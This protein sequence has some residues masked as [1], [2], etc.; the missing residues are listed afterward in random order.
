LEFVRAVW[1]MRAT[2]GRDGLD[3]TCRPGK[4]ASSNDWHIKTFKAV[5]TIR[6][7]TSTMCPAAEMS[8]ADAE[9]PERI[10]IV[11][12]LLWCAMF[13]HFAALLYT[14]I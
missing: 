10:Y 4:S 13:C 12:K 5:E 8:A 7:H 11:Q 1:R 2:D 14:K 9:Y 3:M 6:R